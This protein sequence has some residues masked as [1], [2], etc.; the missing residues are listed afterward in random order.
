KYTQ[1]GGRRPFGISTLIIGYDVDKI[2][3]L[4]STEP[5]GTYAAWKANAIGRNSKTVR[6]FLE[7]NYQPDMTKE[8]TLKLAIRSLLEIVQTGAKNIE[9][10]YM[11]SDAVIKHMDLEDVE[12]I[13]Q[14]IE[15]E[16]ETE[17]EKKKSS[18]ATSSVSMTTM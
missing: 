1:S 10:A 12:K 18:T 17:A 16:K 3:K 6:E 11:E 14:E 4:Y 8:A 15:K 7:K 13:V 5:S 2:P 9:I